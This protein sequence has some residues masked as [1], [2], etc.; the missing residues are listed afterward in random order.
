MGIGFPYGSAD[1]HTL[2]VI[3]GVFQFIP[4]FFKEGIHVFLAFKVILCDQRGGFYNAAFLG[5]LGW[6]RWLLPAASR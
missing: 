2:V 3:D 5:R 1:F 4:K 6:R